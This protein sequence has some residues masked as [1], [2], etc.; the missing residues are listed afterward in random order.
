MLLCRARAKL[1][2][3]ENTHVRWQGNTCASGYDNKR[4]PP[5]NVDT[6]KGREISLQQ[7]RS[8]EFV[9]VCNLVWFLRFWSKTEKTC[10]VCLEVVSTSENAGKCAF[11]ENFYWELRKRLQATQFL[12]FGSLTNNRFSGAKWHNCELTA[13]RFKAWVSFVVD[14]KVSGED[15][16]RRKKVTHEKKNYTVITNWHQW[17]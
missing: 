13:H 11:I 15:W 12:D 4:K 16:N 2:K 9:I 3:I 7:R 8:I 17:R 14:H 1:L 6:Q 10:V 5:S